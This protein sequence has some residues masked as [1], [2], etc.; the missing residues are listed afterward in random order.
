ME[1]NVSGIISII[2]NNSGYCNLPRKIGFDSGDSP[3]QPLIQKNEDAFVG[4]HQ[5]LEWTTCRDAEPR[6]ICELGLFISSRTTVY[7][8]IRNAA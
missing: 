3:N 2:I 7:I 8:L 1:I 4:I 6:N 5:P